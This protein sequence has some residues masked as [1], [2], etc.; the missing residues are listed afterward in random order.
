MKMARLTGIVLAVLLAIVGFLHQ[1]SVGFETDKTLLYISLG[2][3]IIHAALY[4]TKLGR[5]EDK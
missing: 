3:A 1:Q 5:P 4:V 2:F